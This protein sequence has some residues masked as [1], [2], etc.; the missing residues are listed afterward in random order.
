MRR[1]A[2]PPPT[3]SAPPWMSS[4][5][6][7]VVAGLGAGGRDHEHVDVGDVG[8]LDGACRSAALAA[9]P[10]AINV[11]ISAIRAFHAAA[12]S[13]AGH[14][15]GLREPIGTSALRGDRRLGLGLAELGVRIVRVRS[16]VESWVVSVMPRRY[17]V[18][19][20]D[21]HLV[22]ARGVAVRKDAIR[23]IRA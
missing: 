15:C 6:G 12:S 8:R 4:S 18:S 5:T 10:M 20:P 2:S 1:H 11:S 22:F 16:S 3:I 19:A 9:K 23:T 7:R 21:L 17:D 14:A 13:S